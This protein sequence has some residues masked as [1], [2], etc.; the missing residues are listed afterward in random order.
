MCKLL[1]QNRDE[2]GYEQSAANSRLRHVSVPTTK[3]TS[4]FKS[5]T[6]FLAFE[7]K[8]IRHPDDAGSWLVTKYD[9]IPRKERDEREDLSAR[10]E[11]IQSIR[12]QTAALRGMTS[13]VS[14]EA[15]QR[16]LVFIDQILPSGLNA[17]EVV[18][19]TLRLPARRWSKFARSA[20]RPGMAAKLA[21]DATSS[22]K[23]ILSTFFIKLR[24]QWFN[25]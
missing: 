5:F 20:T 12:Y 4:L 11:A 23:Y 14:C 17:V 10:G 9:H 13:R 1:K 25:T 7:M 19:P 6:S 2:K 24:P 16:A 8:F 21:P 18:H 3:K 22:M 15:W